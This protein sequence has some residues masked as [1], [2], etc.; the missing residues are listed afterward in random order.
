MSQIDKL[1]VGQRWAFTGPNPKESPVLTICRIDDNARH[2]QIIFVTVEGTWLP[3]LTAAQQGP[4]VFPCTAECI[5]TTAERYLGMTSD[6]ADI[7]A[8]YQFFRREYLANR[9]GVFEGHLSVILAVY[10]HLRE[11]RIDA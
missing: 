7:E 11:K 10:R 4:A 8:D 9:V 3:L 2:G 5:Q 1:A 6:S